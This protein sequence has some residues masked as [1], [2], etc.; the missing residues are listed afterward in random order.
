MKVNVY[1]IRGFPQIQGGVEK[2]CE[3]IYPRLAKN[4][5][6]SITVFRRKQYVKEANKMQYK[7]ITFKDIPCPNHQYFETLIHSFKSAIAC[8][9]EKPDLVHIHNIGPAITIPLL[10]LFGLK[11]IV[12]YHS[13][14]Y[15]HSKWN[16]IGKKFIK[17]SEQIVFRCS[18]RIIFISQLKMQQFPNIS[19]K[20]RY[21]PNGMSSFSE[22]KPTLKLS[23]HGLK[24]DK[25]I[26]TVGRL[27][28]EKRFIDLAEAFSK[29]KTDMKL[30]IAGGYDNNDSYSRELLEYKKKLGDRIVFTG[31]IKPNNLKVLYEN[32]LFFVLPSENEG[33][34]LVLL[35]AMSFGKYPLV[36][37]IKENLEL[38]GNDAL[39][40]KVK[41]VSDLEA[42]LKYM[43]SHKKDINK[44]GLL[45][46]KAVKNKYSWDKS[47]EQTLETYREVLHGKK[48]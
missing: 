8:I 45:F 48:S 36:S 12:T 19:D 26:L 3:E 37:S 46:K 23:D 35:E 14:N 34:P 44:K 17:M 38:V 9:R 22:L 47:A 27:V 6:V 40:F 32:C 18:D 11:C 25:F 29:L 21:V 33:M 7:N 24:P 10:K 16:W 20:S 39:Y 31:F 43:L 15:E 42:K 2:H 5:D 30:V 13:S 41:D 4:K 28:P 1:G